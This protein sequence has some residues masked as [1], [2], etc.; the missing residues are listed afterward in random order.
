MC[1]ESSPDASISTSIGMNNTGS[2]SL[3][4]VGQ[5]NNINSNVVTVT[6]GGPLSYFLSE[7]MG[8]DNDAMADTNSSHS[9][10]TTTTASI[11]T[12]KEDVVDVKTDPSSYKPLNSPMSIPEGQKSAFV[13]EPVLVS[14]G[15]EMQVDIQKLRRLKKLIKL[16]KQQARI[17]N[18]PHV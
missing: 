18:I 10:I 15:S 5:A 12:N 13:E 11:I 16:Q 8:V 2:P 1:P 9:R 7:N 4:G 17:R 14:K 6:H 3:L